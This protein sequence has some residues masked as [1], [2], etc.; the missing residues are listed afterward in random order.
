MM[1]EMGRKPKKEVFNEDT[2]PT[3]SII[4][5]VAGPETENVKL[6]TVIIH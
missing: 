1:L 3:M 2:A 5:A 4:H 6:I